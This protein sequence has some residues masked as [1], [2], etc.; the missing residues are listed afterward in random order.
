MYT[1][2]TDQIHR[3]HSEVVGARILYKH[4]RAW[5]D[6]VDEQDKRV[7]AAKWEIARS[8]RML[9]IHASHQTKKMSPSH[10]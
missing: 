9:D 10:F 4:I 8:R 3:L 6:C 2:T 1:D 7:P 5:L